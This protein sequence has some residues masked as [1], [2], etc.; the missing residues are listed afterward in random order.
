MD[1]PIT[2]GSSASTSTVS[3]SV[4]SAVPTAKALGRTITQAEACSSVTPASKKPKLTQEERLKKMSE[5]RV[6][7]RLFAKKNREKTTD[8]I[9]QKEALL[10]EAETKNTLL[11][12]DN[13]AL[14]EKILGLEEENASLKRL[15][16]QSA[17]SEDDV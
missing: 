13:E 16:G 6:R 12:I 10:E 3:S 14:K 15:T 17:L 4:A 2:T 7:N 8:D 1:Q 9:K 5:K 11:E